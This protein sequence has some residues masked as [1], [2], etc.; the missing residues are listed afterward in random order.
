MVIELRSKNSIIQEECQE[1]CPYGPGSVL[2]KANCAGFKP[3]SIKGACWH[4]RT[5]D[6]YGKRCERANKG[7]CPLSLI[8][9]R[10]KSNKQIRKD[11]K[12]I[13]RLW[14]KRTGQEFSFDSG[15]RQGYEFSKV[16]K[17]LDRLVKIFGFKVYFLTM[18]LGKDTSVIERELD[19]FLSFMRQRFK[20]AGM[21]WY[22]AWVIELQKKRYKRYGV[23]ALHWHMAIICP[24]GA[25]PDV[26]HVKGN[27]RYHYRVKRDGDVIK[28]SELYK[29]WGRGFIFCC[30]AYSDIAGY[31]GKYM[32]KDKAEIP[33]EWSNLRRFGS[34]QLG[35]YRFPD[36]AYEELVDMEAR[37]IDLEL[38]VI[39]RVGSQVLLYWRTGGGLRLACKLKSPWRVVRLE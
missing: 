34:S 28:N 39:R 24:A 36:W 20:R 26:S 13:V 2:L 12:T 22:Y 11:G 6:A 17:A 5:F 9:S 19:R 16:C 29:R 35:I 3:S 32:G 25:L 1:S 27:T 33:F 8:G 38:H 4:E 30:E 14:N 23:K 37:G 31:L 21:R 7:Y 10:D 18:T 15:D